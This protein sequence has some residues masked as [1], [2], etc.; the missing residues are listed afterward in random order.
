MTEHADMHRM[1]AYL[2]NTEAAA[3]AAAT[4][5]LMQD[6]T[7]SALSQADIDALAEACYARDVLAARCAEQAREII[8]LRQRL[9]DLT[10][11]PAAPEPG[12][13]LAAAIA[14]HQDHGQR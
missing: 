12:A 4:A 13:D 9:H 3:H 5:R 1:H 6:L 14:I 2:V 7:I 8:A 10:A 11:A